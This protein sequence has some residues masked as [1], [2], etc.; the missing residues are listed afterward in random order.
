MEAEHRELTANLEASKTKLDVL[1]NQNVEETDVYQS[2]Q[3]KYSY[4][5]SELSQLRVAISDLTS[6]RDDLSDRVA[7]LETL[8]ARYLQMETEYKA[9]QNESSSLQGDS[10]LGQLRVAFQDISEKCS[11]L[12]ESLGVAEDELTTLRITISELSMER[13]EFSAHVQV[14][15]DNLSEVDEQKKHIAAMALDK[16]QKLARVSIERDDLQQT[17]YTMQSRVEELRPSPPAREKGQQETQEKESEQVDSLKNKITSLE[18]EV[19]EAKIKVAKSLRQVKLLKAELAK[20]K[21][22]SKEKSSDDYFGSAIEEELRKQVSDAE[23][24]TA[25]KVKEIER[26]LLKID[27]LE[28]AS[29]RF[30]QSKER[31]DNDMAMLHQRNQQLLSRISSLEWGDSD[32]TSGATEPVAAAAETGVSSTDRSEEIAELETK[33]SQLADDNEHYQDV[34]EELKSERQAA[35]AELKQH[36]QSLEIVLREKSELLDEMSQ[37]AENKDR[38]LS[39][40][41]D[42][43][44]QLRKQIAQLNAQLGSGDSGGDTVLEDLKRENESLVDMIRQ[45]STTG[46]LDAATVQ[47]LKDEIAQNGQSYPMDDSDVME[48]AIDWQAAFNDIQIEV[49][50]LRSQ[51]ASLLH[52]LQDVGVEWDE[53][54]EHSEDGE[55]GRNS[56]LQ[57]ELDDAFRT[58]HEREMHCQ[59]LTWEIKKL[60]EERDTLQ[61]RLSNALRLNHEMQQ[62][63]KDL[64]ATAS[65]NSPIGDIALKLRE[66]KQ[67]NYSLDVQ[68]KREQE[69]RQTI[70]RQLMALYGTKLNSPF[71]NS[72]KAVPSQGDSESDMNQSEILQETDL[73]SSPESLGTGQVLN[74]WLKGKG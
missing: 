10:E 58:I 39:D 65:G 25:E 4:S 49:E 27:T 1:E 5:E 63:L 37:S 61:L 60:L 42:S 46:T 40:A 57:L 47:R 69:E 50:Y 62:E 53:G 72:R 15:Q 55:D 70:E 19:H 32:A 66:L 14:L 12:E 52:K 11:E 33:L 56:K 41:Y 7:H 59:E 30:L 24:V 22:Q 67:L 71:S 64:S 21:E 68:L 6:E 35:E 9:L 13:D 31:Q 26:L 36:I 43:V 45:L 18:A 34:L 2:L 17:V 16:E 28:G 20:Q 51:N 38:L 74:E 29:D 3:E 8:E 54:G 44:D 48:D 73:N 23:K